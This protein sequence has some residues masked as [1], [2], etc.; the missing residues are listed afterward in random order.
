M[1]LPFLVDSGRLTLTQ[2]AVRGALAG[3]AAIGRG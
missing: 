3:I 2:V 1:S